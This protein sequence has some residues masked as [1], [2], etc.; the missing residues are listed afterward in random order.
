MDGKH[1]ASR[2]LL[3][4]GWLSAFGVLVLSVLYYWSNRCGLGQTYDSGIYI[5]IASQIDEKGLLQAEGLL[6]KPPLFSLIIF[7]VGIENLIWVNYLL[8]MGSILLLISWSQK[9]Q[10]TAIRIAYVVLIVFST[11]YYLV[12][13]FVW[14]EPLF[15]F[16]LLLSF[17]LLLRIDRVDKRNYLYTVMGILFLLPFVRYVGILILFPLVLYILTNKSIALRRRKILTGILAVGVFLV[18]YWVVLFWDGFSIRLNEWLTPFKR[19]QFDHYLLNFRSYLKGLSIWIIPLRMPDSIS[20][21]MAAV[22]VGSLIV[23]SVRQFFE[24]RV[25]LNF[26]PLVFLF[27]YF[28]LHTFFP[29]EYF[30]AERYLTPFYG[31]IIFFIIRYFDKRFANYS[32]NI[33]II[34]ATVLIIQL[35]YGVSRTLKNVTFWNEVRCVE[36][37]V[38]S[39][40]VNH[41]PLIYLPV[42]DK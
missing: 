29:V 9:I 27:Y 31:I 32:R 28:S 8:F 16:L 17:T 25:F 14:T 11:P 34:I 36:N 20:L 5:D 2:R 21:P 10:V 6:V 23:V 35:I 39:L 19:L 42:S 38:E 37:Y 13:G 7:I 22:A 18:A 40:P 41:M 4:R 12:H 24:D 26:I 30:S 3:N 1:K 15:I 33:R